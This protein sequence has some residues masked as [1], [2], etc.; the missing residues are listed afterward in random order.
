[1]RV[2]ITNV[3]IPFVRG[4]AEILAEGL[5]DALVSHG[6][7]AEIV[8]IPF[9]WYPADVIPDQMIAARLYDLTA[10]HDS[11]DRM[12]GLKFPAY[13]I[14]HPKKSLWMVHQ[15][16]DAYELWDNEMGALNWHERGREIRNL[17]RETDCRVLAG[18]FDGRYAISKN[19]ADRA[20]VNNEVPL[21]PLYH[22]PLNAERFHCGANEPY[23]LF[24]SRLSSIKRQYLAI[25]AMSHVRSPGTL[26]FA[27]KPDSEAYLSEL[28][29]LA[30]SH[31]VAD[32]VKFLGFVDEDR[33]RKLM[34]D[35]R[36]VA[37]TPF[38]EDYGYI[39]LEAMLASKPVVTCKD[40][41][42]VLEFI[43]DEVNGAVCRSD[44]SEIGAAFERMLARPERA[45][46][47][48]VAGRERYDRMEI[49]WSNVVEK[50]TA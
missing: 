23:I 16:R 12:I 10:F 29:A 26:V 41:G 13:L 40:S 32:R 1:M 42:G 25:E 30:E 48:G 27:G 33:K 5:R 35:A 18:E 20:R 45:A 6:H 38:D 3:Q 31:G 9:K 43:H 47:M 11:I 28:K 50:L 44:A 14:P 21:E 37:F 34:A 46:D 4:G 22:P 36:A 2:L 8:T 39:T 24:P 7:R 17:V 49:S 19:V 15:H